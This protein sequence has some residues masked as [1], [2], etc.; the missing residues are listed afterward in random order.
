MSETMVVTGTSRGIGAAIA[1]LSGERGWRVYVNYHSVPEKAAEV[2]AEIK[3][4]SVDAFA[5][6]VD[7]GNANDVFR[8]YCDTAPVTH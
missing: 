2:V 5:H 1:H 3:A 6:Q 8:M 7:V 4:C